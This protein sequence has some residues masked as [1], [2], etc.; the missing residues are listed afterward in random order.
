M[1]PSNPKRPR[2]TGFRKPGIPFDDEIEPL[3][4]ADPRPQRV[5]QLPSN[6]RMLSK[7]E[8]IPTG[9]FDADRPAS[10][11]GAYD[12]YSG[13]HKPAFLFVD[14]GPG[15]GQLVP[16]KHGS[17][18]I[19]RA[20]IS[21]LRLQ[22]GSISRRHAQLSRKG[23]RF[24]VKDLGSQNGT[25]VNRMRI[26]TEL[27]IFP[28][29]QIALGNALLKLRGPKEQ[30][31]AV[32]RGE[33]DRK[34]TSPEVR[35]SRRQGGL[36]RVALF[37]GAVG[38]GLAA[39]VM[40]A[41]FKLPHDPSYQD[42]QA[43]TG[44]V[45]L[46]VEAPKPVAAPKGP[47]P[48]ADKINKLMAENA[49]VEAAQKAAREA[50]AAKEL[51]KQQKE[52]EALAKKNAKNAPPAANPKRAS[53]LAKYEAGDVSGALALAKEAGETDLASK[54]SAFQA[55]YDKAQDALGAQDGAG[56]ITAFKSALDIDKKISS[57]FSKYATEIR[58][59]LSNL[60]AL[61]GQQYLKAGNTEYATKWFTSALSY[62][63]QNGSARAELNKIRNGGGAAVAEEKSRPDP[64]E[65]MKPKFRS[66]AKIPGDEDP[67]VK[68]GAKAKASSASEDEEEAPA[69]PAA[70]KK[71]AKA[72]RSSLDDAFNE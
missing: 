47:D 57:G 12:D 56:A 5:P 70:K 28:G 9:V 54:L 53:I 20:S 41:L 63:P 10:E 34:F 19:G 8:Y 25:Y 27:E 67:P 11:L 26:A 29:D 35:R 3:H 17:L 22:H 58:R 46:P 60:A 72:N 2:S 32:A 69:K 15:A 23:D 59:E 52:E 64:D 66:N 31:A 18:V 45:L 68:G 71:P 24:Y 50:A 21:D 42:A 40:F 62:N 6:P 7:E 55:R 38:F 61:A 13:T 43:P 39:V 49:K 51:A 44:K 16:V 1:A 36:L 33:P 4:E 48:V 30:A 14:R 65:D 37:G